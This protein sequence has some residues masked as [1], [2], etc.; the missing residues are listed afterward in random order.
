MS[1]GRFQEGDRILALVPESGR[2]VMSF[3]QFTC[4]AP[5]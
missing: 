1:S 2:F 4:V 3:M 5:S